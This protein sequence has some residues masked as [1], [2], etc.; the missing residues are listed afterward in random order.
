MTED[1]E[2]SA[3]IDRNQ[4]EILRKINDFQ[5]EFLC[6][7]PKELVKITIFTKKH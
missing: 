6:N 1:L 3:E 2:R 4:G 5:H 7:V